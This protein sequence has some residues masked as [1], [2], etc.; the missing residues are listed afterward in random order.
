MKPSWYAIFLSSI[1]LSPVVPDGW[2]WL[3]GLC[4]AVI[5]VFEMVHGQ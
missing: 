4:Y 5:G 1:W 2:N 3:L